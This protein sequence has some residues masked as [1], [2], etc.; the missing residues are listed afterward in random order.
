MACRLSFATRYIG[1]LVTDGKVKVDKNLTTQKALIDTCTRI[2][3]EARAISYSE[4]NFLIVLD[5]ITVKTS[6]EWLRA[7]DDDDNTLAL[8]KHLEIDVELSVTALQKF[9]ASAAQFPPNFTR[10]TIVLSM[11]RG[12]AYD[13]DYPMICLAL[14]AAVRADLATDSIKMFSCDA[15]VLRAP[16]YWSLSGRDAYKSGLQDMR[17]GLPARKHG[18]SEAN[19][20]LRWGVGAPFAESATPNTASGIEMVVESHFANFT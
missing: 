10:T 18:E 4:N 5:G 12:L 20:R 1:G 16:D 19:Y 17:I 6:V 13:Y 9:Q 14:G 2:R 3:D 7:L 8:I 11:A 15:A